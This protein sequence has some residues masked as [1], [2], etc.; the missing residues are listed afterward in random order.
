MNRR[1]KISL[2][3]KVL[4]F[5]IITQALLA[6]EFKL[7]DY[8]KVGEKDATLSV[9]T[10]LQYASKH[11]NSKVIVEKGTY[12]FSES[13]CKTSLCKLVDRLR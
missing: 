7:S 12:H 11:K 2:L 6:Q 4:M 1:E 10:M 9:I 3:S 13:H 8:L 5:S